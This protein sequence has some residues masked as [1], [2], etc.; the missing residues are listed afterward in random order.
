MKDFLQGVM[1]GAQEARTGFF[2]PAAA[3]WKAVTRPVMGRD[4]GHIDRSPRTH[5]LERSLKNAQA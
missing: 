1:S 3:L 2:N 4:E 5:V